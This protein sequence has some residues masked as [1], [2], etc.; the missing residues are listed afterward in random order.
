[1]V[2]SVA[3][4][5]Q[6]I[7]F[8]RFSFVTELL[9]AQGHVFRKSIHIDTVFRKLPLC[10]NLFCSQHVSRAELSSLPPPTG[11]VYRSFYWATWLARRHRARLQ[12]WSNAAKDTNSCLSYLALTESRCTASSHSATPRKSTLNPALYHL[13]PSGCRLCGLEVGRPAFQLPMFEKCDSLPNRDLFDM[14]V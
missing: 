10:L 9:P 1:M 12:P 2:A 8:A 6:K 11:L 14:F 13:L 7:G 4:C 5:L 3:S